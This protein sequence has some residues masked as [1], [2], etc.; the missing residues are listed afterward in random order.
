MANPTRD[1][2]ALLKE[3]IALLEQR[4]IAEKNYGRGVK[5]DQEGRQDRIAAYNKT[6]EEIEKKEK[7]ILGIQKSQRDIGGQLG[8]IQKRY[9]DNILKQFGLEDSIS[10]L[11]D[12]SKANDAEQVRQVGQLSNILDGVLKGEMDALDIREAAVGLTG[13]VREQAEAIADAVEN[14]PDMQQKFKLKAE[15]LSKFD[16]L[17]G[18]IATTIRGILAATGPIGLLLAALGVLAKVVMDALKEAKELRQEFGT[19]VVETGRLL[20]NMKAAGAAAAF[21]GGNMEA[22]QNAVKA[23]VEE[24]GVLSDINLQNSAALGKF[25]ANTGLAGN[26]TA[27]LLKTMKLVTGESVATNLNTLLAA[28]NLAESEGVLSSKVFSDLASNTELFARAG[29]EGA[30]QLQKAAVHAAKIGTSLSVLDGLADNLLDIQKTLETQRTIS[31]LTGRNVDLTRA[32]GLANQNDFAGLA[33]EF[34]NQFGGMNIAQLDRFTQNQI[35][36]GLGLSLEQFNALS[37]GETPQSEAITPPVAKDQLQAQNSTN[38][39]LTRQANDIK[40]LREQ[41]EELLTK[42]NGSI[43]SL[44]R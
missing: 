27:K 28:D 19:S 40:L 41:N 9:G 2:I 29:K 4:A 25:V 43:K 42:L 1:D 6:L 24:T 23:L 15:L 12:A 32:V 16:G 34:Q 22:G 44:G 33:Q 11:K 35:K 10:T 3:Q 13:K 14:T 7:S 20:G 31:L 17:F 8:D 26:E 39:I 5:R 18:G 21:F 37:R 38:E 30:K 36:D